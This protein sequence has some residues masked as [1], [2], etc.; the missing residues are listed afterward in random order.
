MY[1]ATTP[2]IKGHALLDFVIE[3]TNPFIKEATP[4]VQVKSKEEFWKI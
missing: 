4:V 3:A 1:F 2:A